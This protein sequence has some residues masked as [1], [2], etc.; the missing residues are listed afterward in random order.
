M[1]SLLKKYLIN[2]H[3]IVLK[4]E[5]YNKYLKLKILISNENNFK[6]LND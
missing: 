1:M 2:H 6:D 5:Y 4:V 3:Q